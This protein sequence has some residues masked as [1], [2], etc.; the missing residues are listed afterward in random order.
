MKRFTIFL[1]MALSLFLVPAFGQ[2]AIFVSTSGDDANTGTSWET[3]KATLSGALTAATG[4][5]HIYMKVG[6]YASNDVVIPN[7]VT[8]T[9][10]YD[11]VSAGTDTTH[12]Q[13][14]G[15]N[16]RWSN[17]NLCTILDAGQT[18][19][20]ATVN[21][22]GLLEGCILQNGKVTDLGGGVLIDGGTVMHC[23]LIN[24]VALDYDNQTAKGG[25]AYI[26]NNGYLLNSVVAKNHANNG[27]GVAG[28]DGTLTNNTITAN[29]SV[30][31]CG[32]V[33]DEDGNVYK[34]IMIGTQC[35]MAENLRVTRPV[36]GQAIPYAGANYSQTNPYY[37]YPVDAFANVV[38]Y[39]LLYNFPAVL[40]GENVSD[41]DPSGVRGICPV[42]WHIPSAAEWTK[43][44]NFVMSQIPYRCVSN[45]TSYIAKALSSTWGWNS[46]NVV[47]SCGNN[48]IANN[49]S[50]FNAIPAGYTYM[51][52]Y[53]SNYVAYGGFNEE[54][55]YWSADQR[56]FDIIGSSVDISSGTGNKALG[57]SVRCLRD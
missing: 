52:G 50:G 41:A 39:G 48:L 2:T 55:I 7:G 32:T 17:A 8:V 28:T 19:R 36:D 45:G 18:S 16:S 15:P 46:S 5:T 40:C 44:T 57:Y 56:R 47:C 13:Y 21:T 3:A 53:Y 34:T 31:N 27:P 23:V 51:G 38:S 11:T 43:L 35:W 30:A 4:N 6:V 24:N 42:G 10:G 29:V 1:T 9:G 20:V 14:P 22:G 26:R 12:R 25:G 33:T 37:Y 54:A 49:V